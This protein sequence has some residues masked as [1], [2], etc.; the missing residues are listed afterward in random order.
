MNNV[1]SENFE[2]A[3]GQFVGIC[4]AQSGRLSQDDRHLV[5]RTAEQ[6]AA[7]ISRLFGEVDSNLFATLYP[8]ALAE[9][10]RAL[11]DPDASFLERIS[12]GIPKDDILERNGSTVVMAYIGPNNTV[13]TANL[14]DSR[15]ELIM[16]NPGTQTL[17]CRLLTA[18]HTLK[19]KNEENRIQEKRAHVVADWK[20]QDLP[21]QNKLTFGERDLKLARSK[22]TKQIGI[23]RSLGNEFFRPYLSEEPELQSFNLA[24]ASFGITAEENLWLCVTSDGIHGGFPVPQ[25]EKMLREVFMSGSFAKNAPVALAEKIVEHAE[26]AGSRDN[27][28]CLI[29]QLNLQAGAPHNYALM[30]LDG[31][32]NKGGQIAQTARDLFAES[33]KP[34]SI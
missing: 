20:T 13:I 2:V 25:R 9:S 30:V 10:E 19:N 7:S 15:A 4:Q 3:T 33:L 23:T 1:V 12:A 17:R 26:K 6:D 8:E 22:L 14:G 24:D 16:W 21:P 31:N 18:D 32:G 11:N 28:T 5:L 29:T 27:K 34:S